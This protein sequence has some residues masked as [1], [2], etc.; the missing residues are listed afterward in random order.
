MHPTSS[1][2]PA[3]VPCVTSK[4]RFT[5]FAAFA[6]LFP[7]L[8]AASLEEAQEAY[9]NHQWNRAIELYEPLMA[10]LEGEA[11]QQ[12]RL[13]LGRAYWRIDEFDKAAALLQPVADDAALSRRDRV[14][15]G[16]ML[17]RALSD[18][19]DPAAAAEA[20]RNILS[21][22]DID[23]QSF[24]DTAL[25]AGDIQVFE[26][27][28][29]PKG[30]EIYEEALRVR[31]ITG[32]PVDFKR[33]QDAE[34]RIAYAKAL[35]EAP[36]HFWMGPYV[37]HVTPD[38]AQV[39]WISGEAHP[40]G[41]VTLEVAGEARTF[42][43]EAVE[44]R[45]E[46]NFKLQTARLQD[47]ESRTDYEYTAAVEEETATGNFRTLLPRGEEGQVR[48]M[49]YGDT[50]DRPEFH[51]PV[52][53]VMAQEEVDFVLHTGD[54][55][56]KG[57]YF[58]HWKSQFFD[59]GKPVFDSFAIWPTVG[60]HDGSQFFD[61]LFLDDTPPYHTFTSGNVQV[62][63]L[64]SYRS[65]GIGSTA[66]E[67]QLQWLREA[68]QESEA[69]WKIAVTHYPMISANSAHWNNWGQ[70]DFIPLFE[71]YGMDVVFTGHEHIYRRFMPIG[72]EGGPVTYHITS[73]G[74]ASVGG[75][76]GHDGAGEAY[77]AN[78]L[79]EIET[80]AL[81]YLLVE[82][83]GDTLSIQSKLRDGTLLDEIKFTKP[84]GQW[85]EEIIAQA[86]PFPYAT[87]AAKA[88]AALQ[89]DDT[90]RH[91]GQAPA[92]F[93]QTGEGV[94]SV[95]LHNPLPG[96]TGQLRIEAVPDSDWEIEANPIPG[97][98]AV[99]FTVRQPGVSEAPRSVE[100]I[101]QLEKNGRAFNAETFQIL[102]RTP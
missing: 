14:T 69:D 78:P 37:T 73:G 22:P 23:P 48:F 57:G 38:G 58:P 28:D 98:Q 70:E 68:L 64:A 51:G 77:M 26:V 91:A 72:P 60:N 5:L 76:F 27:G 10:G 71:E 12:A 41:A 30:I 7:T 54:C 67:Q 87:R 25:L 56:G 4:F 61:P 2:H 15:A 84:N 13:D 39:R 6:L 62:F 82:A 11:L 96:D 17:G 75:D 44:M 46:A 65:G 16:R 100:V 83:D 43:A 74:G 47:L 42:P 95:E 40:E 31:E 99:S 18:G 52:A 33:Q 3:I 35:L 89:I 86:V 80:R 21:I 63:I 81:H 50:Q 102:N 85:P 19:G 94:F 45:H 32:R 29:I 49:V 20:L 101:L 24:A 66:R 59:P 9:Q 92:T 34:G 88:Y 55:V 36:R 53:E 1:T 90:S 97:G 93:T 79:T 8:L